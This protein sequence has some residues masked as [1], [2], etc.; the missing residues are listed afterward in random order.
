MLGSGQE[1]SGGFLVHKTRKTGAWSLGDP[2][3]GPEN[4]DPLDTGAEKKSVLLC[5][6]KRLL[7]RETEAETDRHREAKKDRDRQR[8]RERQEER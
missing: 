6:E 2:N 3:Q 1:G 8:Q 4:Q 5:M 7:M